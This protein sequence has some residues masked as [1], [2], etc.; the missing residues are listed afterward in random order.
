MHLIIICGMLKH[1]NILSLYLRV[2]SRYH[3]CLKSLYHLTPAT[4]SSDS[5]VSHFPDPDH[6]IKF[7]H[8]H[9]VRFPE[10]LRAT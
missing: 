4:M 6:S 5:E 7:R 2:M 10:L 3:C 8:S 9:S 1:G